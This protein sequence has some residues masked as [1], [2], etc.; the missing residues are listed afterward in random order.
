VPFQNDG[1]NY[2]ANSRDS[3]L[4]LQ[5]HLSEKAKRGNECDYDAAHIPQIED[6]AAAGAHA[7]AGTIAE[8]GFGTKPEN[9]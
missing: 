7:M 8:G 6:C 9:G 1:R 3:T 4:V 2:A 5:V